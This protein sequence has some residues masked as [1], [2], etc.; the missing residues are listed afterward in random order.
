MTKVINLH[1]QLEASAFPPEGPDPISSALLTVLAQL[2]APDLHHA[3]HRLL[4]PLPRGVK[5]QPSPTWLG[6][7]LPGCLG[8]LQLAELLPDIFTR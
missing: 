6:N 8:V 5:G 4:H 3:L 2:E 1:T 7:S